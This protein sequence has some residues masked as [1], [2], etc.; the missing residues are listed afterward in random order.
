MAVPRG[1][2]GKISLPISQGMGP[3]EQDGH[4][5]QTKAMFTHIEPR[6]SVNETTI[7]NTTSPPLAGTAATQLQEGVVQ[8]RTGSKLKE[9]DKQHDENNGQNAHRVFQIRVVFLQNQ[10]KRNVDKS[11]V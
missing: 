7:L 4:S 1:A 11:M 3:A 8:K 9:A 2:S 5:Q 10:R 6:V